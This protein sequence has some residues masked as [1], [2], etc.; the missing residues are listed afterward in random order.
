MPAFP[1]VDHTLFSGTRLRT[2]VIVLFAAAAVAEG[3]MAVAVR[4]NDVANHYHQGQLLL[5]ATPDQP[6]IAFWYVPYPP[7]RATLNALLAW[8]PYRLFRLAVYAIGLCTCR[9]HCSMGR[10][11]ASLLLQPKCFYLPRPVASL[12]SFPGSFETWTIAVRSSCFFSCSRDVSSVGIGGETQSRACGWVWPSPTR[13][14]RCFSSLWPSPRG[15]ALGRYGI[16]HGRAALPV[17]RFVPGVGTNE[18][19]EPL[20]VDLALG[21]GRVGDPSE[22]GFEPARHKNQSLLSAIGRLLR[23]YPPGHSLH[24]SHPLY[25][26]FFDLTPETA[27]AAAKGMALFLVCLLAWRLYLRKRNSAGQTPEWAV[28]CGLCA[29]LS[30]VCWSSHLVLCLPA[31]YLLVR[32]VL[33]RNLLSLQPCCREM[34]GL[35]L[36]AILLFS[37]AEVV[38]RDLSIVLLSYK[39]NTIAALVLLNLAWVS[40]KSIS[41]RSSQPQRAERLQ[42]AGAVATFRQ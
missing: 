32:N 37:L 38:G 4:V 8:L 26:Q 6:A 1:S 15:L 39:V 30:P 42:Y 18:R 20:F 21:R 33:L 16:P 27:D 9:L 13:Q 3:V 28:A 12:S 22:N 7:G 40:G 14:R 34:A 25:F 2:V 11:P 17:A 31:A 24:S 36:V 29:L 23:T 41:L 19:V 5:H 10:L 35:S